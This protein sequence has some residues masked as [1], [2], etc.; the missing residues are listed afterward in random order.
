M[1]RE[2]QQKLQ[3]WRNLDS[4]GGHMQMKYCGMEETTKVE[5]KYDQIW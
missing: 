5:T 4:C 2:T 1:N 3:P